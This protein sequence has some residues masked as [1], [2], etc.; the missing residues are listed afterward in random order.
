LSSAD[1]GIHNLSHTSNKD[2]RDD[3]VNDIVGREGTT[4]LS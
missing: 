3:I 4:M 2:L 1:D